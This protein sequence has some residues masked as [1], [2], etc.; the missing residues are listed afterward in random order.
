MQ[1]ESEN[2]ISSHGRPCGDS[3]ISQQLY[4]TISAIA[5]HM[6]N[7]RTMQLERLIPY[8]LKLLSKNVGSERAYISLYNDACTECSI[9][10]NWQKENFNGN[11]APQFENTFSDSSQYG[12]LKK[13]SII[14]AGFNIGN[15]A[16]LKNDNKM[17]VYPGMTGEIHIPIHHREKMIGILSFDRIKRCVNPVNDV[18]QPLKIAALLFSNI[19][20]WIF[21]F[22]KDEKK[23]EQ[24][25]IKKQSVIRFTDVVKEVHLLRQVVSAK[26]KLISTASHELRTPLTGI[27]GLTQALRMQGLSLSEKEKDNFLRII[28]HEGKRLASLVRD[29]FD[30]SITEMDGLSLSFSQFNLNELIKE[31]VSIIGGSIQLNG[32]TTDFQN[33]VVLNADKDRIKQVLIILLDNALKHGSIPCTIV[34]KIEKDPDIVVVSVADKGLGIS[35][36]EQKRI[37]TSYYKNGRIGKSKSHG[38]GLG[39]AIAKKI[40]ELHGGKIWV[41]SEPGN[42]CTFLFSLKIT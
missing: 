21:E 12:P 16:D 42:G 10:Y 18:T 13:G 38:M 8:S 29:L 23:G 26:N 9:C 33:E 40:I 31:V 39:L 4:K 30:F 6:V 28:E 24:T 20:C 11:S 1:P 17:Q 41:E 3:T 37:F 25:T 22:E 19:L 32:I 34:S 36:D 2:E 27:I 15:D 7:I 5:L 14:F 35:I